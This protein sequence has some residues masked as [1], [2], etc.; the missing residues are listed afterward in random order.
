MM[1]RKDFL[2]WLDEYFMTYVVPGFSLG[3]A[4]AIL[5]GTIVGVEGVYGR[6][7][8]VIVGACGGALI[9]CHLADGRAAPCD[10]PTQG[11]G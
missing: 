9:D 7:L 5:V 2:R 6:I 11:S 4:A 1:T 10:G 3:I 8:W